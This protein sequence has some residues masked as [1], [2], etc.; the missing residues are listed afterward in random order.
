MKELYMNPSG[1]DQWIQIHKGGKIIILTDIQ[2]GFYEVIPFLT[3]QA[4]KDNYNEWLDKQDIRL[5]R[6]FL[7]NTEHVTRSLLIALKKAKLPWPNAKKVKTQIFYHKS[8]DQYSFVPLDDDFSNSRIPVLDLQ[9]LVRVSNH[10][11]LPN[12]KDN[13]NNMVITSGL[14]DK[15]FQEILNG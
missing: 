5:P 1:R 9:Y 4:A 7:I 8:L 10:N 11:S 15:E 13:I 2:S 14:F 3:K 6:S 12:K